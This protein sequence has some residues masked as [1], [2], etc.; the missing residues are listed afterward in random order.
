M[1]LDFAPAGQ[2]DTRKSERGRVR[3]YVCLIA[4]LLLEYVSTCETCIGI[5]LFF[6]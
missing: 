5:A 2:V 4:K 1:T 3:K 6:I